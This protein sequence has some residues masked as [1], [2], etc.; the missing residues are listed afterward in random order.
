MADLQPDIRLE[1][2]L[3][4][5]PSGTDVYYWSF[6]PLADADSFSEPRLRRVGTIRRSMSTDDAEPIV[7]TCEVD[8]FDDDGVVRGILSAAATKHGIGG[9]I[10]VSILSES[11]SSALAMNTHARR[12][13]RGVWSIRYSSASSRTWTPRMRTGTASRRG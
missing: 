1:W 7:A 4:T 3:N 9:E 13:H 12:R 10:A 5:V 11:H 8:V 6:K 2:H